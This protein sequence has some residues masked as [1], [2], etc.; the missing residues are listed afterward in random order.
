MEVRILD[1]IIAKLINDYEI[2]G[3]IIPICFF[4]MKSGLVTVFTASDLELKLYS[5]EKR[6]YHKVI[7]Y[8]LEVI[9]YSNKG[10]SFLI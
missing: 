4:I 8:I 10:K 5:K 6:F 1:V 7:F 3:I 2:I 9:Y